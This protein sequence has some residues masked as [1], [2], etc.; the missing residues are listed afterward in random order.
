MAA[1]NGSS[2]VIRQNFAVA[3]AAAGREALAGA[4]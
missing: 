1:R 4:G 3:V 2:L